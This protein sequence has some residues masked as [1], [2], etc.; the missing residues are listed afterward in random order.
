MR[1]RITK[2]VGLLIFGLLLSGCNSARDT[3][4][5]K[6]TTLK[7]HLFTLR[8][9]IDEFTFD[10]KRAPQSLDELVEAG[11]V[12]QIPIDPITNRPDWDPTMEVDPIGIDVEIGIADVHSAS[13]QISTEGTAYSSW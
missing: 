12:K 13:R 7:D 10:K 4:R 3:L 1:S 11:Y 8:R 5:T 2:I 6:E 9:A